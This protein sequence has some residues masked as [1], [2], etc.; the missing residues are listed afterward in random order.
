M[1]RFFVICRRS[2][3]GRYRDDFLY[4]FRSDGIFEF[5]ECVSDAESFPDLDKAEAALNFCKAFSPATE[6]EI[7]SAVTE[8]GDPHTRLDGEEV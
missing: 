3:L 1:K 7:M 4:Y 8:L 6:F 2:V 5:T